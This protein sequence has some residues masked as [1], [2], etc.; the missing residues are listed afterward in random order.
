VAWV[1]YQKRTAHVCKSG[2]PELSWC[3]SA[4]KAVVAL[5]RKELVKSVP[6]R[7]HRSKEG[8]ARG[9]FR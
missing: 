2:M 6:P 1:Q 8:N 5:E 9:E 7:G 3:I 4:A